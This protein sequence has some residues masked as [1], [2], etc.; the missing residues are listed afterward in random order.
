[1]KSSV[2][3]GTTR[4]GVTEL[5]RRWRAENPWA[6]LLIVHGL[7][8]HS[9]RYEETGRLLAGAGIEVFG[10]DLLGHGAS[11]GRR[12]DVPSW[13]AFLEQVADNLGRAM[14]E[15]RPAVLL[16]HS[17]GGLI[18]ASYTR[19]RHRQ[20]DLVAL[21]APALDAAMPRWK[22]RAA[23][24]LGKWAPGLPVPNRIRPHHLSRDPAVGEAYRADP[25]TTARTRARLGAMIIG[26]MDKFNRSLDAYSAPTLLLHGDDDPV[27]PPAVTVRLGE[28]PSVERKTYPGLRHEIFN[29]PE[30]PQVTEDLA[31]W[32]RERAG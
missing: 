3:I 11:G 2:R 18:A 24:V 26:Q 4:A 7:G 16:G 6:V 20:P 19:S 22:R 27:V 9:G 30:G 1:M 29:E 23:P 25:L 15:G 13:D 8:E 21:S 14:G 12:A 5:T 32:I 28:R 10:F 17:L 31:A